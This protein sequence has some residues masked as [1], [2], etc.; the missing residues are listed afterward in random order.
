MP[1]GV[2]SSYYFDTRQPTSRVIKFDQFSLGS[3][4]GQLNDLASS[5]QPELASPPQFPLASR[6]DPAE[7]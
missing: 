3:P 4:L 6:L 7:R 1:E 5:S 2:V